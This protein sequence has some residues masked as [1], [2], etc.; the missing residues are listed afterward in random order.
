MK[1][2]VSNP[3]LL[4]L[5]DLI[6]SNHRINNAGV[7]AIVACSEKFKVKKQTSAHHAFHYS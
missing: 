5:S 4:I 6:W 3:N 7:I 1:G 2:Y